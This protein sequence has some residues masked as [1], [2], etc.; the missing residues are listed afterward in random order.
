VRASVLDLGSNSFHVLVADLDAGRVTPVLRQREMLHLGAVVAR[1]GTVPAEH[2]RRAVETVGHLSE[3]A[4]RAGASEQHAVA[5]SALRDADDGAEVIAELAEA[6][7]TEIRV[8][9]G[10]EEARVG[11]LGVRAAVAVRAEPVLVLDL[12][13]GSLELTVGA[14]DELRWS[15]S[16]PLGASRLSTLV[17]ADPMRPE[18]AAAL[19]ARVDRHLDPLVDAL[20]A[21]APTT[22]IAVGGTVRA[23]ARIAA[24]ERDVWLPSTLNQLRVD[25]AE[26]AGLRDRLVGLDLDG[27]TAI[28]GM[29]DRRA[30]HLHVAAVV[31][32]RVLERLGT[33]T[34]TISDWG[35]REGLLLDAH[36]FTEVPDAGLLR[37]RE[38]ER[39]RT[40]FTPDDPHPVHV[41]HLAGEIFDGTLELH[42]LDAP[43]RELL[44]A[45]AWLHS[46]GEALALR[47]QHVHGAYLVEH[48]EL[49]GFDPAE[50]AILTTLVRYH[51]SRGIDPAFPPY[52]SLDPDARRRTRQ[53]LALLQ[54]ADGLD[55]ARDQAVH[56]VS[57]RPRDGVVELELSGGGLHITAHELARRTALFSATFDV[58]V[59]IVDH[60]PVGAAT[61]APT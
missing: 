3:L 14:G 61:E 56:D 10:F 36:G 12:G 18:D 43:D 47:R 48:A 39:L 44:V 19:R 60:A 7:G 52:A 4:R 49:R 23:M 1:S 11:Y 46:I 54:V 8:L 40:T 22:T 28:P 35:L 6:A 24:R 42:G 20:R 55:R 30:D 32:T 58:E 51:P 2:R 15:T 31:L 26:L 41:A 50:S 13:G 38:I 34:V 27:R 29:K 33:T 59:Q 16:V 25:A 17:E 9:D 21:Q 5:T 53:L 45:A 37:L 57:V